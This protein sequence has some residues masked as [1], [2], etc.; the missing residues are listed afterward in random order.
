M[1]LSTTMHTNKQE[2]GEGERERKKETKKCYVLTRFIETHV[3][4]KE[5][6]S[7]RGSS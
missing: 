6:K 4:R 1:T 2:I 3:G 5:N 7:Q